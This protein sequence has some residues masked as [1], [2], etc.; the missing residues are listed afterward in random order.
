M[1]IISFLQGRD[2]AAACAAIGQ[3]AETALDKDK[4]RIQL[5]KRDSDEVDGKGRRRRSRRRW[6]RRSA[7]RRSWMGGPRR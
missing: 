3:G 6:T 7:R 5:S 1:F 4:P 2:L